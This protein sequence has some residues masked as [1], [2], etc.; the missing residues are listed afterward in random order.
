MSRQR[1]T[2]TTLLMLPIIGI[3]IAVVA[4]QSIYMHRSTMDL[5]ETT[6][7]EINKGIAD[8]VAIEL[9]SLLA[10]P[11]Y[12]LNSSVADLEQGLLGPD[13]PAQM[14]ARFVNE[15]RARPWLANLAFGGKD[16]SYLCAYRSWNDS[17]RIMVALSD[18][19][20]TL[21]SHDVLETGGLSSPV[22]TAEGFDV[23]S[24]PW[25]LAAEEQPDTRWFEPYAFFSGESVALGLSHAVQLPDG[26]E[27]VVA[28]DVSLHE[29]TRF[30]ADLKIAESGAA[31]VMTADGHLLADS[32]GN[33]PLERA[34]GSTRI[35]RADESTLPAV[36]A[37]ARY[38][39]QS[40]GPVQGQRTID[41]ESTLV[42][43]RRYTRP[44]GLE[45]IIGIGVP[46]SVYAPILAETTRQGLLIALLMA[47][48]GVLLAVFVARAVTRPVRRLTGAIARVADGRRQE[49]LPA[50]NIVEIDRVSTA[51]NDMSRRMRSLL[52]TMEAR[53][54][55][56]T[57][58]LR[59]ANE[60]LEELSYTDELTGLPNRRRFAADLARE[61]KRAT[62]SGQDLAVI[63][64]DIDWFKPF[65]DRLG[66][67]EGDRALRSVAD[68]LAACARRS[69]DLVAR[70]GGEEFVF[71]L[72]ETDLESA[73]ELAERARARVEALAVEH[74]D[75]PVAR[76][77]ISAGVASASPD[78]KRPGVGPTDLMRSAD[79]A[80][81]RAKHDGRNRVRVSGPVAV[82]SGG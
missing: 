17:E 58:A 18:A 46:R 51:F 78:S 16:G 4:A 25:F 9:D 72:P 24:R 11:E 65:N 76:V 82:R 13:R 1:L 74:P 45:L 8:G 27:G 23:T 7:L 33:P 70:V 34:D 20:G 50:S 63:M 53:V 44:G 10:T 66:H 77:T 71:L 19:S 47:S 42:N 5:A 37:I 75:S 43:T 26:R 2:L 6:F 30:L 55:E 40:P 60:K 54:Q 35:L 14:Q 81:Y 57:A 73:S 69:T 64:C 59:L 79:R 31:F 15:V 56:R 28:V 48:L 32:S 68:A 36:G 38:A 3:V 29:L 80:L 61:W 39:L 22:Q 21:T 12:V 67:P 52:S 41:G 62:R 49:T